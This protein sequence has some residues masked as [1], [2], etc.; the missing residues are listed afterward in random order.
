M[1]TAAPGW[2]LLWLCLLLAQGIIPAL[3]LP[4]TA[5]AVDGL[6]AGLRSGVRADLI[7]AAKVAAVAAGLALLSDIVAA[8]LHWVNSVQ[9][10]NIQDHIAS[11]IHAKSIEVDLHFY[12]SAEFYDRL[13]RARTEGLYRP[14]AL[15]EAAGGVLQTTVGMLS[16]LVLLARFGPWVPLVL[17]ASTVPVFYLIF[18]HTLRQVEFLN[19]TASDERRAGY[20]DWLLTSADSAAEIR[21][22]N[23]GPSFQKLYKTVRQQIRD[24]RRQLSSAY[25]RQE[26]AVSAGSLVMAGAASLWMFTRLL[27]GRATM[28]EV[29]FFFQAFQQSLR[30]TTALVQHTGQLCANCMFLGG[31]FDFLSFEPGIRQRNAIAPPPPRGAISFRNVSF[32]YSG[33][34]QPSVRDLNLDIPAGKMCAIVGQNGAGKSTFI[35]L[36][37]R[38]YDPDC[39]SIELDGVDIRDFPVPELRSRIGVVCQDPMRYNFTA[40]ENI[41]FGRIG[42]DSRSDVMQAAVNAEAHSVI[43]RLPQ[44]YDTLL[45]KWFADGSELSVGE[46][47]RIA[48]ARAFYA[49]GPVFVFDEPTSAMDPWCE[50]EWLANLRKR[51][52]GHTTIL[53]THRLTTA[54]IADIVHVME[55]GRIVESGT[56]DDLLRSQGRYAQ[57]CDSQARSHTASVL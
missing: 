48:L 44:D 11:E 31:L 12:E 10:D 18:R 15:M 4:F 5:R 51:V 16:V 47:Q 32:T 42:H 46:W 22:F 52:E 36:L 14:A 53:V 41:Q 1:W 21:L 33:A 38:L 26:A 6:V 25:A 34:S 55:D 7:S 54:A 17:G 13:H 8:L 40:A 19:R 2:S 57:W 39:G 9:A 35:K 30:L 37:C 27:N 20:Y 28:G 50:A 49:G 24:E 29:V 56:H 3:M 45:G 23:L 43:S